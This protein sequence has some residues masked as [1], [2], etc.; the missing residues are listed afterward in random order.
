MRNPLT[1]CG[2]RLQVR[3]PHTNFADSTYISGF[4]LHFA[5]STYILRNTLTVTESRTTSNISLLR[6]P[7]QN[8]CA[9]KI[10]ATGICMRNPLKFCLWNPLT[11]RNI[12]K[13]LSME[14][15][16]IQTKNCAPIQC[17]VWLV[18]KKSAV[19]KYYTLRLSG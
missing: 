12:F 8:N 6:N 5:D 17:S 10:N 1:I 15:R 19:R 9:E 13:D 11:F 18:K 3:I 4:H 2:I 14:S 7:Q 16:N